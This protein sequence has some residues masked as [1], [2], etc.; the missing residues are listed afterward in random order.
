MKG[1]ELLKDRC[2][3]CHTLERV[4]GAKKTAEEWRIT[5]TLMR[6]KGAQLSN[7]EA[8]I[9]IGYLASTYK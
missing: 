9:L 2:T 6:E 4:Q 8:T 1:E 7:V 5:V 3:Q